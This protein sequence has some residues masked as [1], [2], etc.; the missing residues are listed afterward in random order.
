MTLKKS[1]PYN[2]PKR[3]TVD[4]GEWLLKRGLP[5]LPEEEYTKPSKWR[6]SFVCT[7]DCSHCPLA[8]RGCARTCNRWDDEVCSACPCRASIMAQG[9]L[10]PKDKKTIRRKD[11]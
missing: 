3:V 1:L 7:D 6:I 10:A 4:I 11:E 9:E 2:A 8:Q 5:R